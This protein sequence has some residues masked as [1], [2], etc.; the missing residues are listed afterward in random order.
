MPFLPSPA[1]SSGDRGSGGCPE[2]AQSHPGRKLRRAVRGLQQHHSAPSPVEGGCRVG[3]GPRGWGTTH[4]GGA[5]GQGGAWPLEGTLAAWQDGTVRAQLTH[6][7]PALGSCQPDVRPGAPGQAEQRL[8]R[9]RP[10]S[11]CLAHPHALSQTTH[12]F[13]HST[14]GPREHAGSVVRA[15]RHSAVS[16]RGS[17]NRAGR[18]PA[19]RGRGQGRIPG[20]GAGGTEPA[21]AH[22]PHRRPCPGRGGSQSGSLASPATWSAAGCGGVASPPTWKGRPGLGAT[23]ATAR[24]PAA[25]S[26][27]RTL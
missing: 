26:T 10:H 14:R 24:R 9:H 27:L 18:S 15:G 22:L 7:E 2:G 8:P 5:E 6:A 4:D 21:H 19:G 1:P 23:L 16:A 25:L 20:Q 3:A 11:A 17:R 13:P 12:P